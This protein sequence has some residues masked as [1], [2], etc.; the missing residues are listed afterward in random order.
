LVGFVEIATATYCAVG[1]NS[2]AKLKCLG[3]LS[4]NILLYRVGLVLIGYNKPCH[5]LGDLTTAIH[6]SPHV[7]DVIMRYVLAYILIGSCGIL[8]FQ[9]LKKRSLDVNS[10]KQRDDDWIIK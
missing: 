4:L 10:N 3:C 2:D 6:V 1:K 5:C 9:Y 7:A 8:I